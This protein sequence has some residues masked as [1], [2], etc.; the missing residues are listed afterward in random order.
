MEEMI[1]GTTALKYGGAER[2]IDW[3]LE[4]PIPDCKMIRR[5]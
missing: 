4:K 5:E 3:S 2:R 1:I